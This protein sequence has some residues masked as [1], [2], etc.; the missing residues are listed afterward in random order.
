MTSE[1]ARYD[2][3]VLVPRSKALMA[4]CLLVALTGLV[5]A[6]GSNRDSSYSNRAKAY[7]KSDAGRDN[8]NFKLTFQ[9][10]AKSDADAAGLITGI[11]SVKD[12]VDVMNE[13]L[14]LPR[15]ISVV[16]A[17]TDEGP[18]YE[19]STR[20]L[21]VG[22]P[23]VA[24]VA[25]TFN[26]ADP[27]ISAKELAIKTDNVIDFVLLHEMGHALIDQLKIPITGREEDSADSLATTITAE[28]LPDGGD[29][30][31]DFADF[32]SLLQQ[33]PSQLSA[34]DFW[35]E[36]SLDVQ[37]ANDAT[38]LVYGSNPKKYAGLTDYIPDDRLA[39]CPDQWNQI[40]TSWDKL[41]GP[42][43]KD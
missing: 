10:P 19:P 38:C 11:G 29:Y 35:D 42:Y 1:R 32:F 27:S 37:R 25:D 24:Y 3:P 9:A 6:C 14:I 16:F 43:L 23:F 4:A 2:A 7:A 33:D 12:L 41:L 15:D 20:T 40:S 39:R 5:A 28:A 30:A 21:V 13:V 17:S 22:Y 8:G 34:V 26:S 18:A 36:H 31:L